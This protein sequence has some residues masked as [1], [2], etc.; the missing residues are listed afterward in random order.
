M[1][2]LTRK[3]TPIS[4]IALLIFN[5][6]WSQDIEPRRW[7]TIPLG[8]QAVGIG[9]AYS[10]GDVLFD[11]LL[12]TEDVE[13]D[14]HTVVASYVHPIRLGKKYGRLDVLVPASFARWEGLLSG[15]PASTERNGLADP[16]IRFSVHLI[17]PPALGPKELKEYLADKSK[18][19]TFGVSLAVTLPLGQYNDDRLL[20][21]GL[22]QFIFR[23]QA[24]LVHN[25]GLWSFELTS[26]V[27]L[28]TDNNDF[29][30]DGEKEQKPLF[31]TQTHLIKF[32]P[33]R[34]WVAIGAAYGAGG[35]SVVN[36]QP[37]ND[38]RGNFL[39]GFSFGYPLGKKQNMKLTYFRSETLKD[40]GANTNSLVLGW[41]V[42]F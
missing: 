12:E 13:V 18:Y 9:Y 42:A 19:T 35:Q 16:R 32:F 10:F 36:R 34:A 30:N 6:L 1:D 17:G 38:V 2:H 28:F 15:I 7:G 33:S 4:I 14:V 29:F 41:S 3:T 22:N 27:L 11:P 37:N 8:V 26:S 24:G 20:N 5:V 31:S 25:W 23:P 40:I 21:L 39:A